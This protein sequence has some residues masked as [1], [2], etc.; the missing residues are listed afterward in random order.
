MGVLDSQ[1][2]VKIWAISQLSVNFDRSHSQLSVKILANSQ[3]S[4]EPHQEPLIKAWLFFSL[5]ID[6]SWQLFSLVKAFILI[7]RN[8]VAFV[9]SSI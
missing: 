5:K 3:L 1:L 8:I 6:I 9:F 4:V 7:N 2:S